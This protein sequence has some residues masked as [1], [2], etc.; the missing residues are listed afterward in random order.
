MRADP[1][2]QSKLPR[3]LKNQRTVTHALSAIS[4]TLERSPPAAESASSRPV[5]A[6]NT[7][8][9]IKDGRKGRGGGAAMRNSLG[10]PGTRRASS[11][12]V[13]YMRP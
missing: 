11:G 10:S 9:R 3:L 12:R 5:V 8:R 7:S 6:Y 2:V 4:L 13:R 1:L